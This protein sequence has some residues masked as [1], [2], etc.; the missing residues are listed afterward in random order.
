L[1]VRH[2]PEV[3][4]SNGLQH[5]ACSAGFDKTDGGLR[6]EGCGS[7][8]HLLDSIKTAASARDVPYQSLIKVW[9]QEKLEKS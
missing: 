8:Q 7:R 4:S 9:L 3:Q 5:R 6:F 2:P 1:L